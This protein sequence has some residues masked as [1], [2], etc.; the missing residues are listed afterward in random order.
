MKK[1]FATRYWCNRY[2]TSPGQPESATNSHPKRFQF[3]ITIKK[4]VSRVICVSKRGIIES[5]Y[6]TTLD[7]SVSCWNEK[8][9][10]FLKNIFM[11]ITKTAVF[12]VEINYSKILRPLIKYVFSN[13]PFFIFQVCSYRNIFWNSM[14]YAIYL[15]TY[16]IQMFSVYNQVPRH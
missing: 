13:L 4:N 12:L 16:I 14:I 1:S 2:Y 9:M 11:A 8:Q 3:T 15:C 5:V 7:I 10:Y 6:S